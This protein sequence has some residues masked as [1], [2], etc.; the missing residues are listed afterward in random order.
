MKK[1]TLLIFLLI[2][3]VGF[4]QNLVTN[5]DFQTG[6]A[7]PWTGGAANVVD[8]G[9]SNFVNQAQVAAAGNPWDVNLSQNITLLNGKTYVLSFDA[10]TDNITGTRTMIAGL[11]QNG[12]PYSSLSANPAL[13]ATKQNFSY[14]FTINY[15]DAVGD[16][17]L[18][19]MGAQKGFVF[20]DNVS[21]TEFVDATAPTGFTAT[22]GTIGAYNVELLLNA[23]DDSGSVTYKINYGATNVQTTG[24][25]GVQKSFTV[26]GLTKETAYTFNVSA[27]DATGNNAVNNPIILN[28]TT[29][30]DTSTPCS[31]FS[32]QALEGT[33]SVGYNYSFVT[34]GSEVL[35]TFEILDTDKQGL[36]P[37]L[38]IEPSTFLN[39][40]NPSG[41]TYTYKFTGKTTGDVLNF[42]LRAAYAGGLVRSKIFN[43]TVGNT[44]ALSTNNFDLTSF[45]TYPNPTKDTWTVTTKNT[46]ISSIQVYDVSGRNVLSLKPN[47]IEAK[48]DASSLKTGVYFARINTLNGYGSLKLIKE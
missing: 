9:G 6:V 44:C 38:F 29:I 42:S 31:G 10:F 28:A 19:D 39:M 20:I 26:S 46:N 24:T 43:Y 15:G 27:S 4:S 13:T 48:I 2:S 41:K 14:K 36:S 5:G 17:V 12:A 7:T 45:K 34:S 16:R 18:F 33:F 3:S 25:S 47:A 35:V 8:L 11:G 23:T 40:A 37:Q 22:V 21:V 1:I 32:T 30:A